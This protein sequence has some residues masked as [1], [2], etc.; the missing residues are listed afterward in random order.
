MNLNKLYISLLL[1]RRP[2]YSNLL[3]HHYIRLYLAIFRVFH[4]SRLFGYDF[5]IVAITDTNSD[6]DPID[7][8]IPG[9]DD[10]VR[11]VEL[12]VE[13]IAK[14]IKGANDEYSRVAAERKAKRDAEAKEREEQQKAERAAR[15]AASAASRKAEAEEKGESALKSVRSKGS[16]GGLSTEA[17]KAVRAAK[18]AAE[19]KAKE[20]LAAKRQ[21]QVA[22]A[23]AAVAAAEAPKAE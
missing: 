7:Y 23:E 19:A 17:R 21:E 11:G 8:V 2:Y 15:K 18:E 1:L 6:P 5:P 10:S 13:G 22:A 14:V 3:F 20:A 4:V 12:I 9:N 16:K